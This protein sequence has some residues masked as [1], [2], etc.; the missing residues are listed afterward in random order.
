MYKFILAIGILAC[1]TVVKVNAQESVELTECDC[2]PKADDP[3]SVVGY[4]PELEYTVVLECRVNDAFSL[5]WS[6]TELGIF[7]TFYSGSVADDQCNN[8]ISEGITF[9]LIKKNTVN[10]G[11]NSY[12]SQL[13][14]HTSFLRNINHSS[15]TVV[16]QATDATKRMLLVQISGIIVGLLCHVQT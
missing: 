10:S 6:I 16:C 9:S 13:R 12:T 15:L 11:K 1:S 5:F 2:G 4:C 7:T 3:E 8:I 14:V